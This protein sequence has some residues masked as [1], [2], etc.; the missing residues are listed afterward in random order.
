MHHRLPTDQPSE[1]PT[2]C[3]KPVTTPIRIELAQQSNAHVASTDSRA[4]DGNPA[5]LDGGT[6]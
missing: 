6:L 3:R 4:S 2:N 1:S 5:D